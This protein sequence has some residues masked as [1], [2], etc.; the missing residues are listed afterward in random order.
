M[1]RHSHSGGSTLGSGIDWFTD[2]LTPAYLKRQ[3]APKFTRREMPSVEEE[4]GV[5]T[6]PE[7][8]ETLAI[9]ATLQQRYGQETG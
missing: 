6:V 4:D 3:R 7:E 2:K 1:R 8:T 9:H 5:D